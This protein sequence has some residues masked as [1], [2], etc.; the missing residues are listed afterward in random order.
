MFIACVV[1]TVL[2][3]L[4]LVGSAVAKLTKQ[5]KLVEQLT[6]LGVAEAQLPQ[7]AGLELAGAAGMLL[8]LRVAGLGVLA[9]ACVVLYFV[10]AVGAH[11]RAHDKD[12]AGALVLGIL[13]A[14][15]LGLRIATL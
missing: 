7:L 9:S 4:A 10:G 13:A 11:V 6:G 1:I 8:G 14:V 3:S 2:V 12:L 5:Q 15:A